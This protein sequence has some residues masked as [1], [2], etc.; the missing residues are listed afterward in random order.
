MG[1]LRFERGFLVIEEDGFEP[2]DF[3]MTLN[4]DVM[5]LEGDSEHDF[6]GDGVAEPARANYTFERR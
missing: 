6:D 4:D 3:L 1:S 2:I 5:N